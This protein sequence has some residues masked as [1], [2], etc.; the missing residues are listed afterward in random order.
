MHILNRSL[1]INN[2]NKTPYQ[3]WK[4]RPASVKNFRIFGSKCYIKRVDKNMGKLDSRTD[5]GILVGYSC[6]RKA[7]K[8]YNFRL[9]KIVEAIDVKFDES[10]FFKSKTEKKDHQIYEIYDKLKNEEES[11]G[12]EETKSVKNENVIP[13]SL[14]G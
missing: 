6:S 12:I 8:C 11:S 3:L 5:E 14:Q 9:K 1:L 4:G 2:C 7:Y 10:S 13:T